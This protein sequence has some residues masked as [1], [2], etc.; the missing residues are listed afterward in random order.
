MIEF[1]PSD[2]E[3]TQQLKTWYGKYKSSGLHVEAITQTGRDAERTTRSDT[4]PLWNIVDIHNSLP[5]DEDFMTGRET[6]K[7][8]KVKV[9][10]LNIQSQRVI[11]YPA[12]PDC[13]K[14][15]NE[16]E[17]QWMCERCN[18]FF[19]E[20]NFTYNFTMKL[21]DMSEIIYAQVLGS[22]PGD[23]IIGMTAK[24]LR[25]LALTDP[26][27]VDENFGSN[28]VVKDYL[29]K[30]QFKQFEVIIK[31]RLDSMTDKVGQSQIPLLRS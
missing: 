15:C 28:Q 10:L 5:N 19:A 9:D 4:L 31:A 18:K 1:D 7:Y 25:E 24:E 8:F 6:A 3:K 27:G 29:E 26:N 30:R 11:W 21:G 20:P 16:S 2:Q 12:C 14:K 22:Y 13:K 23:E 17:G